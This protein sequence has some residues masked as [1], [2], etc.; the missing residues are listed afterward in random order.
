MARAVQGMDTKLLESTFLTSGGLDL[1]TQETAM[2]DAVLV[3]ETI[4]HGHWELMEK[5]RDALP[6]G[7]LRDAFSTAVDEVLADEDEHLLWAK[8]TKERMVM[9]QA[10]SST[11]ASMGMKAEEMVATIKGWFTD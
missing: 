3:A 1:M 8:G 11:A 2:L 9:L 10:T 7:E 4:D 5:L 6:D